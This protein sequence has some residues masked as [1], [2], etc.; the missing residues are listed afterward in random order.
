[1]DV[2]PTPNIKHEREDSRWGFSENTED[3]LDFLW[4]GCAVFF[5]QDH[6][7]LLSSACY[8][9]AAGARETAITSASLPSVANVVSPWLA[10]EVSFLISDSQLNA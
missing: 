7:G 4:A 2:C 3:A 8:L 9:Y 6:E 1:M 10:V 5:I